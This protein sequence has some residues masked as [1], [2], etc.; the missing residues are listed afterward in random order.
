MVRSVLTKRFLL[1][2]QTSAV[3]P[4]FQQRS[5]SSKQLPVQLPQ[6]IIYRLFDCCS[7][8][9][10]D[11]GDSRISRLL[12]RLLIFAIG[13]KERLQDFI[14]A[15][16]FSLFLVFLSKF[17]SLRSTRLFHCCAFAIGQRHLLRRCAAAVVAAKELA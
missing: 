16:W 15:L 2:K 3:F 11:L 17:Q 12:Q 13:C 8:D 5:G 4:N 10:L 7:I 1:F 6:T 9:G 14:D